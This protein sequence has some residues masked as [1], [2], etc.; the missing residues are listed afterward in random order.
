MS[1]SPQP[2]APPRAFGDVR[3]LVV[4]VGSGVLAS[5]G[6][7]HARI[8]EGLAH[9][10]AALRGRGLEVA[11]VVSGAV[12]AGYKALGC[13]RVPSEVVERQAAASV[14]QHRLMTVL[15]RAFTRHRIHVAQ[16]LLSADDIEHR[17]RFLSA[18]HTL[19]LM[20]RRGVVPIINENDALS[21]D[22][23]KVG[24]NDH[25]AAL[26]CNLVT[27]QLLVI[28]SS[29]H[30]MYAE[31]EGQRVISTV[32]LSDAVEQHLRTEKS[33]TGVGGFQAKV[34]AAR[35][36]GGMG[37][38]TVVAHGQTPGMLQRVLAGEPVGTLFTPRPRDLNLRQLW[39]T[40]RTRSHGLLR[41]DDG[42][43]RAIIERNASLLP[44]GILAVEGEFSMGAR[45]DI[46]DQAGAVFAVGLASY[47]AADIRRVAG[48]K[49]ADIKS[50]LG[51]AYV[52][53]IVHRDDLV[54]TAAPAAGGAS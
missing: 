13:E 45:V 9:D 15:A 40:M 47:P 54:V 24:D 31:G 11:L 14:G 32:E 17:R 2:A 6:R 18:R 38:P 21:D 50:I 7:F 49:Q 46:V 29:V 36:A 42:A 5:Q 22:E 20:I 34:S 28:L 33:P 10:V 52:Q 3:R 44:G 48:V 23:I 39:I 37:V 16:L 51:Y 30:G 19:N 53:E 26:V 4:K 27:A 25:L 43:R 41:V 12:A 8:F 35:L 1:I